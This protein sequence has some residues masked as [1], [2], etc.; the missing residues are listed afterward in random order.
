MTPDDRAF[1]ESQRLAR[2]GTIARDGR[3]HLVPVCFA[4]DGA[5][6]VVA[7]DE[8]PK[9]SGTLAR[10]RNIERDARVSLLWDLYDDDWRLLRWV[11]M[12]GHASIVARGEERP[13]A[14]AMLRSRYPQYEAM[15]LESL[16]LIAINEERAVSW[17]WTARMSGG[18]PQ[19]R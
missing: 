7:I 6:V 5:A 4:F 3:P 18:Q 2:L 9:A 11:R 13:H 15:A 10:V 8:K 12:D 17:A 16:P 14:L 19:A 1:A